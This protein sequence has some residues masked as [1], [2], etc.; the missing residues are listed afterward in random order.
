MSIKKTDSISYLYN[1]MDPSE[2]VEFERLLE[3]NENLLIEVESLRN[4]SS[5][6]EKLPELSAPQGVIQSV[7]EE[8]SHK[9]ASSKRMVKKPIYFA[10]AAL[11][12]IGFMAGALIYESNESTGN[13][14]AAVIGSSGSTE[15]VQNQV[16]T[17]QNSSREIT[18][19]VDRNDVLHFSGLDN[20]R[21]DSLLQNSYQRLT[22][23]NNPSQN[24][25]YQ[26]NLQLTGSRQ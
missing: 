13:V 11:L 7:C 9:T 16:H 18:P 26:R 4:V 19:W 12:T 1:E 22:R 25:I 24:S 17:P 23:V 6:L 8:A 21:S 3:K 14:G 15:S 20:E 10:T 2:Q 5:K